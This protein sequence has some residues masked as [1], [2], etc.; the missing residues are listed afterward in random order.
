MYIILVKSLYHHIS[1]SIM[2]HVYIYI[3][4]QGK[5]LEAI[6]YF[7][8]SLII[9]RANYG[10]NSLSVA[11]TLNNLAAAA[12]ALQSHKSAHS[13]YSESLS[14]LRLL[15]GTTATQVLYVIHI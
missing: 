7:E 14:I 15:E 5:Y 3:Y 1:Y 6:A 4:F 8:K 11:S 2:I 12:W 10:N 13:Y 9:Y